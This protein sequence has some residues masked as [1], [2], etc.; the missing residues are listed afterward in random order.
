MGMDNT[1]VAHPPQIPS[2]CPKADITKELLHSFSLRTVQPWDLSQCYAS[3]KNSLI[4]FDVG[5]IA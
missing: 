2:S 3:E 4:R 1:C 5:I